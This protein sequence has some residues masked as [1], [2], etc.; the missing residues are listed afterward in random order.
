MLCNS[1]TGY[2]L[3]CKQLD[4]Y[5]YVLYTF[6]FFKKTMYNASKTRMDKEKCVGSKVKHIDLTCLPLCVFTG[7]GGRDCVP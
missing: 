2:T 7:S 6:N 1:K 3:F 5:Y 4:Y